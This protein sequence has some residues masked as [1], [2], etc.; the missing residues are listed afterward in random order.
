[1]LPTLLRVAQQSCDISP[2]HR[3]V[4]SSLKRGL[5]V[6]VAGASEVKTRVL[7]NLMSESPRRA[8]ASENVVRTRGAPTDKLAA[9]RTFETSPLNAHNGGKHNPCLG[10]SLQRAAC[11]PQRCRDECDQCK[12]EVVTSPHVRPMVQ[13]HAAAF[14]D[15]VCL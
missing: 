11:V 13:T 8:K 10:F 2:K 7:Q 5:Q 9:E 12:R 6:A 1:M 14:D 4:H 3:I 15:L